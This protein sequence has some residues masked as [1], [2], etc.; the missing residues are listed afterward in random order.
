MIKKKNLLIL[1]GIIGLLLV[2]IGITL[3]NDVYKTIFISVGGAIL[4][5]SLSDYLANSGYSLYEV[6]QNSFNIPFIKTGKDLDVLKHKFYFYHLTKEKGT[7]LWF[8]KIEDYSSNF[9]NSYIISLNNTFKYKKVKLSYNTL[10]FLLQDRFIRMKFA[11]SGAERP[12]ICIFNEDLSDYN[13]IYVGYGVFENYDGNDMFAPIIMSKNPLSGIKK[14][15]FISSDKYP[16]LVK[17]LKEK[18]P[19]MVNIKDLE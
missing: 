12:I 14:E 6:L 13:D 11:N 5:A 10:G 15:G 3:K 16:E 8:L 2:I 4:G 7:I 1:L 18:L 19:E 17:I 9:S